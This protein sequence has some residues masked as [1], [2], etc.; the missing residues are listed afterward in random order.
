MLMHRDNHNNSG[1]S[2]GFLLGVL[3]G[4]AVTLMLTTKKGRK[5]LKILTDEGMDKLSHW[6]D[7]VK[8]VKG[9][10]EDEDIIDGDDYVVPEGREDVRE[11]KVDKEEKKER[12]EESR[13]EKEAKR[14]V[15]DEP[16]TEKN[17]V[18]HKTKSTSRRFFRGVRKG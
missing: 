1:H 7:I 3:I 4:V 5:I 8:D 17:T 18:E 10:L 6:E 11:E 14:Q 12:R 13:D 9:S 16:K 2:G 15:E